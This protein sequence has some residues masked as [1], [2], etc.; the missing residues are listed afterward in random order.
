[1][2]FREYLREYFKA[3]YAMCLFK[4]YTTMPRWLEIFY[5]ISGWILMYLLISGAYRLLQ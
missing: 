1:M 3:M 5:S 2:K 4:P